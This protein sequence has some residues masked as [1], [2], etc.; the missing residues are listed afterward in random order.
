MTLSGAF[1]LV[2]LRIALAVIVVGVLQGASAR[3]RTRYA[4]HDAL[5]VARC[6]VG[7]WGMHRKNT[8]VKTCLTK[9]A[10]KPGYCSSGT[11]ISS[12]AGACKEKCEIDT[13]CSG[14]DKCCRH[15]CGFTCQSPTEL[16]SI[17]GLPDIPQAPVVIEGRKKRTIH[18]DWSTAESSRQYKGGGVVLYLIEERNHAGKYFVESMLGNWSLCSKSM[19]PQR[20]LRNVLKPGK[21]YQFRVAAVNENGTR[22][23]SNSSSPFTV[24]TSPKPPKSP[25]NVTIGQLT[26]EDR[27]LNAEMRWSPSVSDIPI[28]KYIVFW[29]RRLFGSKALDS[30]L[31]HQQVIPGNQTHFKLRNLEPNSQYFLQIQGLAQFGKQRLKGEKSGDLLNTTVN[32]NDNA[33]VLDT[34]GKEKIET[35]H[36][37]KLTW[38]K[39]KLTARIMWKSFNRTSKSIVTWWSN[40][41]HGRVKGQKHFK[42]SEVTKANFFILYD[43]QFDCRY[44]VSVKDS[45][46]KRSKAAQ[47]TYVT[48]TT[49]KCST[50]KK[51]HRKTKCS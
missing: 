50:F 41:C 16:E 25:E 17:D 15:S 43:L 51:S 11:S 36:L 19:R 30:V 33:L 18:I 28:Q 47:D 12:F 34:S 45:S 8:C 9:G 38:S 14:V 32:E 48:F 31:V 44:R 37:Q 5:F 39:G 35:L 21:W 13:N 4:H 22:G 27:S 26:R 3:R 42:L 23:F 40:A 20:V 2:V 1:A 29:S 49:P 10:L 7:C 24:T 6:E 46:A